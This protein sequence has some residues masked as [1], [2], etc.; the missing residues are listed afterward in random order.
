[1]AETPAPTSRP[2]T[3]IEQELALVQK[4]REAFD[5]VANENL[6][7]EVVKLEQERLAAIGDQLDAVRAKR[8]PPPLPE[9]PKA[10][11]EMD[12]RK[13]AERAVQLRA[14]PKYFGH[15]GFD[16]RAEQEA[17]VAEAQ[18]CERRAMD[19]PSDVRNLL[20]DQAKA[21]AEALREE[22][23]HGF[24]PAG[25]REEKEREFEW[26]KRRAAEAK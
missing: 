22:L 20:P 21:K 15:V 18:A 23:W 10:I 16:K 6:A 11:A 24:V 13:A 1:M 19:L 25:A 12:P 26:L 17:L 14:D 8:E 4:R 9:L 7:P 2:L 3:E 5:R